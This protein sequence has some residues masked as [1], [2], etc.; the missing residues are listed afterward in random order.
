MTVLSHTQ[1]GDQFLLLNFEPSVRDRLWALMHIIEILV[2]PPQY[3]F[4]VFPN[5]VGIVV[6]LRFGLLLSCMLLSVL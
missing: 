3:L 6:I 1:A 4:A 2:L 5:V